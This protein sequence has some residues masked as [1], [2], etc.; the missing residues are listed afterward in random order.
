[1]RATNTLIKPEINIIGTKSDYQ[2]AMDLML[3]KLTLKKY[4]QN[5]IKTYLH[6]FKQFLGYIHPMPLHQVTTAHIMHYHKELVTKRSVS[7]SYQN[8]SINAIKFY[9]EKVLNLPKVTYDFCRPRKAKTLPKVL[10][11]EE[12]SL[13]LDATRN[14]KHKT[15]LSVIYGCGLRISECINLKI[16]DIDSSN[17]R[18]WV[19]NAK[20]KKDRITLLSPS[21]LE[22]LRAYYKVYKP[23]QWLFES[24]SGG[25]Y[26]VSSIRQ[27]FNRSRKKAGVN[28]PATV[29]TLRHSFATHLL[30]AG[31]N[32][33]Y[34][35]KLL[36][37]GSSKTTEIYT[38]VSTT[39]LINIESPFEKIGKFDTFTNRK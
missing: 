17:M 32:L 3:Q 21:L 14:I 35:Q 39:N 19:R 28:V 37:H 18:V 25:K 5:T 23:K 22:Q 26:S 11:L 4:S 31:T 36:G 6:M 38:H 27:V 2:L 12:V 9:I 20:G 1:M 30:D 16:E 13:I 29:H 10:S 15:I 34:I 8:Q 33:R 24:P 7:S